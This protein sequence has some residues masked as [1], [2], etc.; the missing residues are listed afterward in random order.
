[1]TELE[2]LQKEK[3]VLLDRIASLEQEL[4]KEREYKQKVFDVINKDHAIMGL[5]VVSLNIQNFL[6]RAKEG[7]CVCE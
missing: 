3:K 2:Q 6:K 4:E 1:M 5:L 7:D